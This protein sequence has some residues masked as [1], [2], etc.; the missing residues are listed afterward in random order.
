MN[1]IMDSKEIW[2]DIKGFPGYQVSNKGNVRN[3]KKQILKF[4]DNHGYKRYTFWRKDAN[5][6][7]ENKLKLGHVLVAEAFIENPDPE[8][9]TTVNHIDGNKYNNDASNLEWATLQEQQEHARSTGLISEEGL[10]RSKAN[11]IPKKK[12]RVAKLDLNGNILEEF[13]SVQSAAQSV[14]A[15]ASSLTKICRGKGNT[16]KGFKWKYLDEDGK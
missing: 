14:N 12:R 1:F 4:Q 8:N 9:K 15:D 7:L 6:N 3:K 16:L 5:G 13:D 11:L 10:A 2:K